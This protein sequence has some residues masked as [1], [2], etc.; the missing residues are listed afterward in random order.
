M[1]ENLMRRPRAP[2]ALSPNAPIFNWKVNFRV[3]K[4]GKDLKGK[5]RV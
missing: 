5:T 3:L 4:W 1:Y 2:Y